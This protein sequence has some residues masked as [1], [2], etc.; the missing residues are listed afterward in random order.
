MKKILRSVIDV[1]G[2]IDPDAL[3]KNLYNLADSKLEFMMDEDQSVWEFILEYARTYTEVPSI[4]SIRDYFEKENRLEV[5]DRIEEIEATKTTYTNSDFENLVRSALRAQNERNTGMLLKDAGHILTNGL[6]VGKGH[7]KRK[8]T[9]FKDSI[10]YIMERA[11]KLLMTDSGQVFRSDITGDAEVVKKEFQN[12]LSNAHNAFGRGTGLEDIDLMC[13]GVKPGEFWIHAAYTGELKTTFALNW[14]YKTACIFKYNVYYYSLEMPVEQVRRILYVMHSNHPKFKKMGYEP[15]DYRMIRDGV[16]SN[17][18]EMSDAQIEFFEMVVQD[19]EDG[20]GKEY[21]SIFVECPDEPRTTVS[22]V[23]S[24]IELV[25]QTTPIHLVFIDYLGLLNAERN[26]SDYREELNSIFRD[27]KQM[28]LTFNR[29]ER[30]PIVALHQINREGKKEADKNDGR[31][32]PQALADSSAAERTADVIT[33]TYLNNDLRHDSQTK[34]GCIKNRDN[35]HF[36]P[37]IANIHFP[38]RFISNMPKNT[39][40]IGFQNSLLNS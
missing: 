8:Y 39:G 21:G 36:E 35:P 38:S 40:P 22:M 11:D 20:F 13:R 1:D 2:S 12:T 18:H 5:L 19:M 26:L 4:N 27:T 37:F 17:G 33:Y 34:I 28:C 7:K 16:D 32:T 15:L 24:R 3:Q 9:G 10:R 6:T 25:H 31:Y 29:G 14:A 23:K 30:I